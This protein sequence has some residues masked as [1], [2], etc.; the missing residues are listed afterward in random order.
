MFGPIL[1]I[2]NLQTHFFNEDGVTRAVDGVSFDVL[3]GEMLGIV[4]GSGCG[5]SVTAL[6]VLQLL[7]K[8]FSRVVGGSIEFEGKDLLGLDERAMRGI[9]GNRI[10]MIFQEPMTSLNPV[11]TIGDQI[12][13]VV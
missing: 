2:N 3:P 5:K 6:S 7:P 13:E 8:S 9:R 12:S 10:S 1:S 4:G 11:L